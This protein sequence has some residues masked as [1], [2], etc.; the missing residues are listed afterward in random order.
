MNNL[1]I[2]STEPAPYKTDL[3]NAF[4]DLP[5]WNVTVY[6]ALTKSWEPDASH[7]FTELP[8][9]KYKAFYHHGKGLLG[10]IASSYNVLKHFRDLPDLV[11]VCTLNRLPFVTAVICSVIG[12]VDFA[13]WDDH[14]NVGTPNVKLIFSNMIRSFMRWLV[15]RFSK[16]VLVCGNYGLQTAMKVGCPEEKLVN[17]PYVVD[18]QRLI[19]LAKEYK[20]PVNLNDKIKSG[21]VIFFSGRM[22]ERK[23]LDILLRASARLLK[24]DIDFFL[25]IEGDG[26]LKQKYENM[27]NELE[28]N[29][30]LIFIGFSQ[31]DRHAYLLSISDIVVVPST[32]DPWGIVVHEGMLM[33][34]SVCA[35]DAVCSARDR[36]QHGINGILFPSGDWVKL[37]YELNILIHNR[38]KR[39]ALGCCA[40]ETAECWTPKR[41]VYALL[42][43]LGQHKYCSE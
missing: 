4:C 36:I 19:S 1:F 34:K 41:N 8:D 18:H 7:D 13:F 17:F 15:F 42:S 9:Q 38:D 2:I 3:Y 10:Q 28:L 30:H 29:D 33:G 32:E 23:G 20:A 6:Y 25:I 27:A 21:V 39:L 35:S 22:I 31:M 11:I 43:H 40:K 14:F 12:K 26:P 37:A 24:E 5:D 16:T